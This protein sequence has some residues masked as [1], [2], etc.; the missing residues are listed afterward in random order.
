MAPQSTTAQPAHDVMD[1]AIIGAGCSGCYT[2]WRLMTGKIRDSKVLQGWMQDGKLD[3]RMFEGGH[4]V[5][6][7]LLSLTP[8]GLP[9]VKCEVG[10]MRYLNFQTMVRSLVEDVFRF[11]THDLP[12]DEPE[13]IAYLRGEHFHTRDYTEKPWLVPYHLRFLERGKGLGALIADAIQKSLDP[14]LKELFPEAEQPL[15]VRYLTK[16]QWRKIQ[17][18]GT[19]KGTK[20]YDCGFWNLISAYISNEAY[21]MALDGGGY[22]TTLMNWNAA[23]AFPW[24]LSD[25]GPGAAYNALDAGYEA[26]PIKMYEEFLAAGGQAQF[27]K[28]LKAFDKTTLP[29]GTPGCV[30]TLKDDA[31]G[32]ET[33][34][35]AR[36][37][38]LA[39]PRRAL[40]LLDRTGAVMGNDRVREMLGTVKPM[41]LFKLFVCYPSAWWEQ[42][43]VT[44]GRSNTDLPLRQ[45]YYWGVNADT[46]RAVILA[47]Y[48]D[49][50]NVGFWD[51]LRGNPDLPTFPDDTA[52]MARVSPTDP[53]WSQFPAPKRMVETVHRQLLEL[54]GLDDAPQP[55]SAAFHNWGVD[56]YGGGVNYWNV[57]V[58]VLETIAAIQNPVS[59]VPAYV[60]GE[61]YS[62]DQGWVEG[63]LQTAEEM[64]QRFMDLDKPDWLTPD[65]A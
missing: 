26:L 36:A 35:M 28:W 37:L 1:V 38:V 22:N 32:E 50:R 7:R 13:N 41:A 60:V 43:G 64:L 40:E 5:G 62:N 48:D 39:M 52:E 23:A 12:A 31:S 45:C 56:P 10:G 47:S 53:R 25:F 30:F 49:G 34:H 24:Y 16:A 51:G 20:L 17:A 58:N 4:R 61:A 46:G 55:Y 2:G 27:G 18:E 63:A 15:D 44:K 3:V 9:D 11:A 6:G 33:T 8:P 57:N 54:H 14:T 65:P 19:Y 42:A 59:S 21:R 29:D